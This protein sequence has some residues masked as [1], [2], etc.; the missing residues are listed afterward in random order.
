MIQAAPWGETHHLKGPDSA[1]PDLECAINAV[2]ILKIN[3][4]PPASASGLA[5]EQKQLLCHTDSVGVGV[6]TN[7][8]AE[9]SQSDTAYDGL[10][11]LSSTVTPGVVVVEAA[12]N[13]G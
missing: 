8:S 7:I 9:T 1:D 2:D 11:G 10:V 5:P 3:T 12:V 13:K 6:T 4:L